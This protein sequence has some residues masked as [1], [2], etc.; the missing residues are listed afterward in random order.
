MALVR[1]SLQ[2]GSFPLQAVVLEG[3]YWK[4]R[5]EVV[6]KE[7]HKWR[8]YHKKRVS[9]LF[10]SPVSLTPQAGLLGERATQCGASLASFNETSLNS[11]HGGIG[12]WRGVC[13]WS[14]CALL[15]KG[16]GWAR[17]TFGLV[18]CPL[19]TLLA[20]SFCLPLRWAEQGG[21]A[22]LSTQWMVP[23]LSWISPGGSYSLLARQNQQKPSPRLGTSAI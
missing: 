7:Y 22:W 5:I 14:G 20:G 16:R 1:T 13:A 8:I 2:A 6:M 9:T 11:T 3:K 17:Q 10:L 15:W 18:S 19:L 4:R 12:S 23:V 21:Q